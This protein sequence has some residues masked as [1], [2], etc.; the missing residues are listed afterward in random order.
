MYSNSFQKQDFGYDVNR[1]NRGILYIKGK[2]NGKPF[3]YHPKKRVRFSRK[4][5]FT[6]K[7]ISRTLT[8]YPTKKRKS[9]KRV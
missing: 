5:G 9:M 4:K 2:I 1:E 3:K 8:P 6:K 7:R